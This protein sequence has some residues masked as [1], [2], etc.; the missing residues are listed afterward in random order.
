MEKNVIIKKM[1]IFTVI[2]TMSLSLLIFLPTVSAANITVPGDYSTIQTAIDNANPGDTIIVS[3]GTYTEDLT[4][5]KDITLK[6]ANAGIPGDGTRGSESIIDGF[7]T[8][9][10]DGA[11]ID[12]F[13]IE[14]TFTSGGVVFVDITA[15]DVA[16]QNNIQTISTPSDCGGSTAVRMLGENGLINS[17]WFE[18][19]GCLKDR[20]DSFVFVDDGSD[21][22]L[23]SNNDI[24]GA[25]LITDLAS[26]DTVTFENNELSYIPVSWGDFIFVGG[27]APFDG[28]LIMNGNTGNGQPFSHSVRT[29]GTLHFFINLTDTTDFACNGP[30]LVVKNLS[31]DHFI[32]LNCLLI[33]DAVDAAENDDTIEVLTGTYDEGVLVSTPVSIIGNDAS[34]TFLDV[35]GNQ[36]GFYVTVNNVEIIGFTITN[37][38]GHGV[39]FQDG[40]NSKVSNN[41]FD[42]NIPASSAVQAFSEVSDVEISDNQMFGVGIRA[43]MGSCGNWNISNNLIDVEHKAHHGIVGGGPNYLISYNEIMNCG[44]PSDGG[45]HQGIDTYQ[46]ATASNWT[47]LYNDIH[48]NEDG[49]EIEGTGHEVHYNN[50]YNNPNIGV[51]CDSQMNATCNWWG[52]ITGPNH[53]SNPSGG[54]GCNVSDNVT[55]FPWLTDA[56]PGGDCT[57]GIVGVDVEQLVQNRGF[58]IRHAADGDWG[59]AQNFT[60]TQEVLTNLDIHLRAFGDP[61][62]DLVVELRKNSPTGLLLDSATITS[63][64]IPSSWTWVGLDFDDIVVSSNTDYFIVLPPAPSGVQTSYGYEWGYAFGNQYDDGSFWFT[65]DGG[66]LWRDLPTM[67]EFVF[68]TYGYS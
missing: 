57:G 66:A 7:I 3:A 51:A 54:Y 16:F 5:D 22:T 15:D 52:N 62:F 10:G 14:S 56:Y 65:R 30:G 4:I 40:S 60:P 2:A 18:W 68:K 31:T 6:G 64:N 33:Q 47:I 27:P 29:S 8:V 17:N 9:T 35:G 61:E 38:T 45:N 63:S 21:G 67:Y 58:P 39:N 12:G 37:Y 32:V 20:G 24:I 53:F 55:Y 25:R 36:H 44:D 28:T 50:I 34:S 13:A 1:M 46:F 23:V 59:G 48:G 19:T 41:I 11:T 42:P 49:I 43:Y 26:T